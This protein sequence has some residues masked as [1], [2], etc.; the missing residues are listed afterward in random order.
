[1]RRFR[2]FWCRLATSLIKAI[3]VPNS[4]FKEIVRPTGKVSGQVQLTDDLALG[5]YVAYEWEK[6]RLLPVGSYLSTS[7][8]LGPGAERIN[9][10]PVGTFLRQPDV[11]ARD[12]GQGGLQLRW[13]ASDINTDFG[14]Y[15]IRF[16]ALTPS[17]IVNTLSGV[18]PAL[19]ASS[20]RWYYHEGVRAFGASF[21]KAVGEWGLAGELSFRQNS[22][23]ASSGQRQIPAAGVGAGYD[24]SSNPPYAVGN[25]VHANFSWIASLSPN[26]I[27]RESS[28]VG[29]IAWNQRTSVTKNANMLNPNTDRSAT[30][31]RLVFSPTYR[32]VVPGLDLT[33]SIGVGYTRGR[34]S[35]LGPGFGVHKGGD[36]NI[37]LAAVYLGRWNIDLRYVHYYGPEGPALDN[38]SNAQFKQALKD[39]DFITLS[40]RTTF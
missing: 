23:L 12:S 2:R 30:A 19:T 37:G 36:A 40:L 22:P 28:F 5:A 14:L 24:N 1:L 6:S 20:Y 27:A 38:A 10:G 17:N 7:D 29:E 16:H 31:V 39:R 3:S 21:A 11:E 9:A 32:Q 35:A 33:P 8:V 13:R 25:S 15:A 4:Q 18:P 26:F 34:S